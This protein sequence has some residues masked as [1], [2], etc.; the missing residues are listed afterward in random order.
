M[1]TTKFIRATFHTRPTIQ[2]EHDGTVNVAMK[3]A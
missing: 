1:R 2:I 3:K